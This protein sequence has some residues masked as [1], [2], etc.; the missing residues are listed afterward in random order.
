MFL[1]VLRTA[2][3]SALGVP[4]VAGRAITVQEARAGTKVALISEDLA[5]ELGAQS[6]VGMRVRGGDGDFEAW[7]RP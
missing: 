3:I 5:R 6:P 7:Y 4:I 2:F 1:P